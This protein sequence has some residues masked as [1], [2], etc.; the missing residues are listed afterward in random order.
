MQLLEA[1]WNGCCLMLTRVKNMLLMINL[2]INKN[3]YIHEMIIKVNVAI[4][5]FHFE[6]NFAKAQEVLVSEKK[7]NRSAIL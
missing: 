6:Y 5:G 1:E 3:G 4:R 7:F 2:E